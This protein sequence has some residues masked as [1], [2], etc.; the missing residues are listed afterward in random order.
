MNMKDKNRLSTADLARMSE[1]EA[2]QTGDRVVNRADVEPHTDRAESMW[3]QAVE[4]PPAERGRAG[5]PPDQRAANTAEMHD[6][7]LFEDI[8]MSQMRS[9]WSDIQA[10]FVDEPRKA[11]EQADSLVA[12]TMQRL[13]QT[14]AK[15][16]EGLEHQWDR[17]DNVTTED[18][19]ITLQRYRSFFDRLLSV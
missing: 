15:A 5:D 19:R 3:S 8:D 14:F 11:V 17:G 13:A 9:R 7:R 18:L 2:P 16:R 6:V 10:S 4:H 1:Y 12:E